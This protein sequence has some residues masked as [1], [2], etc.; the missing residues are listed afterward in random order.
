M[1]NEWI[2]SGGKACY[3]SASSGYAL[4]QDDILDVGSLYVIAFTIS[5][6]TQGKLI[7]DSIEGKPEYTEDGEYQV[8]G[9]ANQESLS[10]IGESYLGYVFDG[11]LDDVSVRFAPFLIIEDLDG[12]A[13][14]TQ[15]DNTGVTSSS[16]HVQ[17]SVDWTDLDQGCYRL[18]YSIN[19]VE[20]ISDCIELKLTHDCTI[21][22]SWYNNETA[23]GLEYSNLSYTQYLRVEAKKWKPSYGKEEKKTFVDSAGNRKVLYSRTKKEEL[24]TIA[25]MPE[26]LHDALAIGVEHDNFT[27]DGVSYVCEEDELIPEWRNSSSLAPVEVAVIKK[28]QNLIN[29]NCE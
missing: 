13:V 23:F 25:E 7:L 8:I 10:F 21:L 11:C 9:L 5:G 24:L 3:D 14:W 6:M 4:S 28:S 20:Y 22:L 12:N 26:Y 17:Y 16:N 2:F 15:S 18:K 27:I 29:S 1:A 19:G